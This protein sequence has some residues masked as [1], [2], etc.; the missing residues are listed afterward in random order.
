MVYMVLGLSCHYF[1]QLFALFQLF[2]FPVVTGWACGRTSSYSFIPNFLNIRSCFYYG[3]KTCMCFWGYPPITFYQPFPLFW[4]C[5]SLLISI[6]IGTLWEQLILHFSTHHFLLVLS[7]LKMCVWFWGYPPII[8]LSIFFYFFDLVFSPNP[9]SI[10]IVTLWAQLL[11]QFSTDHFKTMLFVL[12]GLKMC[13]L[14]WGYPP[15]IPIQN[16]QSFTTKHWRWG[17]F[18]RNGLLLSHISVARCLSPKLF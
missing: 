16:S 2:F 3:L 10:L 12:H 7:G 1:F 6:R 5:F 8:F 18:A 9:I 4:R 13:V 17:T 11:L 15:I 14:V